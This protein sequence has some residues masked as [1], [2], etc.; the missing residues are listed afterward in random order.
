MRAFSIDETYLGVDQLVRCIQYMK[1]G[2]W[3]TPATRMLPLRSITRSRCTGQ[4]TI[5]D[6]HDGHRM[7]TAA[8]KL[9]ID[10]LQLLVQC[11]W[12]RAP[13]VAHWLC[14]R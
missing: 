7:L 5:A 2:T 6:V 8:K 9:R 3:C 4:L 1:S 13:R 11:H 12:A 10:G 14:T